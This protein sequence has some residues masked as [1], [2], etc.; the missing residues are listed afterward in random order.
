MTRRLDRQWYF[1]EAPGKAVRP[2]FTFENREV[3]KL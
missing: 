1:K 2:E 3:R